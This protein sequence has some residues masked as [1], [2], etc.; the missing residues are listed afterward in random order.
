M[1]RLVYLMASNP[2]GCCCTAKPQ[3]WGTLMSAA[4]RLALS[5]P[6]AFRVGS[7][8][9]AQALTCGT[10]RRLRLHPS[11]LALEITCLPPKTSSPK[12]SHRQADG[13]APTYSHGNGEPACEKRWCGR[14]PNWIALAP[15]RCTRNQFL[16]GCRVTGI[17]RRLKSASGL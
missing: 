4:S 2:A 14:I 3:A 8:L 16:W 6:M 5:T 1:K 7:W 9:V 12:Y 17:A 10:L 15:D 13:L 11:H